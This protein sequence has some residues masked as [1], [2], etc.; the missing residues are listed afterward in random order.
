MGPV[1]EFFG[2]YQFSGDGY[3]NWIF[4]LKEEECLAAIEKDLPA[5]GIVEH[6]VGE[7]ERQRRSNNHWMYHGEP[8]A[9]PA[10]S[11]KRQDDVGQLEGGIFEDWFCKWVL[12]EAKD[13]AV[14]AEWGEIIQ[15]ILCGIWWPFVSVVRNQ[16]EFEGARF[17]WFS[18]WAWNWVQSFGENV[19]GLEQQVVLIKEMELAQ[20][21]QLNPRQSWKSEFNECFQDLRFRNNKN[22]YFLN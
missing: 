6:R 16:R 22:F 19:H 7:E 3:E 8:L 21:C 5:E 17:S 2:I 12:V 14:E 18:F 10:G 20:R 15:R 9:V 4:R 13:P 11:I 1:E